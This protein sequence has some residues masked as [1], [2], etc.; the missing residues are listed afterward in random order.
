M[1]KEIPNDE[2]T[3]KEIIPKITEWF[4]YLLY[5][6]KIIFFFV[7]IG[8]ISGLIYSI[9]AKPLYTATLSFA[10]E[11]QQSGMSGAFGL[12]SQFGFDIGGTGGGIFAGTNLI[13]LFKSRTILER[14]LLSPV[15]FEGKTV[16]FAEMYIQILKWR[17]KWAQ[18]STLN[19]IQFL[20]NADRR[21][22]KRVQDSILG[23][24]YETLT[25]NNLKVEQRDRKIDIITIE[26]Q[27]T[28]ENFAKYFTESLAREVSDFYI[29]TKS[30]KARINME[31][32]L[33]QTDSIRRELNS[34]I[35][36]V[37]RANDNTFG[38]NPALNVLRTPSVRRQV[39]VQA[40]TSILTELI[41]QTEIA[42]VTLRKETPLIQVIDRPI[43]PLRKEKIGKLKA[44]IL[45]I[46][47]AGFAIVTSLIL[48]RFLKGL[49]KKPVVS[50]T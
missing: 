18:N 23:V 15:E 6:W 16:S 22:F 26:M 27:S 20:P 42:K 33:K 11:D 34:A 4:T 49:T 21:Q 9:R 41:K 39:D 45:G 46:M 35:N 48:I 3:L 13:E 47:L 40:N 14:T 17:E 10:L 31:I 24:L 7:L 5:H 29:L 38:L 28:N 19:N 36:G 2:I 37:A 8:G 50:G 1:N 43:F 30:Q 32:L 44:I 25:K 12:A